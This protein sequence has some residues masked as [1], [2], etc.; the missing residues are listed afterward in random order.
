MLLNNVTRTK[1]KPLN[2]SMYFLIITNK[3]I[4]Q[5]WYTYP[6]IV[7]NNK[8]SVDALKSTN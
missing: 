3:T 5:S 8:L 4:V 7:V 2:I 1:T 6:R